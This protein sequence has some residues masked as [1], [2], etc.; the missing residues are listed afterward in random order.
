MQLIQNKDQ[1]FTF[2]H[3][4]REVGEKKHPFS[5]KLVIDQIPG[6]SM[7]CFFKYITEIISS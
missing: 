6:L 2:V 3:K 4:G 7:L 5:L 1:M